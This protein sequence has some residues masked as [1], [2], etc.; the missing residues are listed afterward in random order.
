M[1]SQQSESS[2]FVIA[3]KRITPNLVPWDTPALSVSQSDKVLLILITANTITT[4]TVTLTS[5]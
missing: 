3:V 2:L 1:C 5:P 4:V